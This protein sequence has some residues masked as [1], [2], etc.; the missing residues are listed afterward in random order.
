MLLVVNWLASLSLDMEWAGFSTE[1]TADRFLSHMCKHRFC[2]M[3]RPLEEVLVIF[4]FIFLAHKHTTVSACKWAIKAQISQRCATYSD[5]PL[6]FTDLFH[7]IGLTC[8]QS[9]MILY[10]SSLMIL[11]TF[12]TFLY[13]WPMQG[14][15]WT[16]TTFNQ[17]F[18][19]FE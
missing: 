18:H 14:V 11:Q 8:W 6:E 3:F 13:L 12:S 15:T 16:F 19:K 4:Y 1:R 9:K 7:A 10:Q 17:T 2:L 5:P